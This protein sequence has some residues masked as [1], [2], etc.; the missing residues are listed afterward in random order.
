MNFIITTL[1]FTTVFA[2]DSKPLA[3]DS[4]AAA[5]SKE[6]CDKSFE[7]N[8]KLCAKKTG[9]SKEPCMKDA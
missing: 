4:L 8:E 9:K 1:C 6:A 3:G 7:I 2:Q 5:G